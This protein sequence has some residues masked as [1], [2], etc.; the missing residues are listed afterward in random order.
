MGYGVTYLKRNFEELKAENLVDRVNNLSKDVSRIEIFEKSISSL[1]TNFGNLKQNLRANITDE[2]KI[3]MGSE[4][5]VVDEN[6]KKEPLAE[7]TDRFLDEVVEDLYAE[8]KINWQN[9]HK[10]KETWEREK[11][12]LKNKF[13]KL[14]TDFSDLKRNME[15]I[16]AKDLEKRV[17][18]LRTEVSS[19]G[20]YIINP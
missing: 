18:I 17:N 1:D 4:V 10:D 11:D 16:K 9:V 13:T 14:G 3:R 7:V 6:V 5:S 8:L 12:E 20:S 15:K 19:M 2:L